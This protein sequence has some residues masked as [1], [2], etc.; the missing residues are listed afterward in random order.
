MTHK[1]N[2]TL[3]TVNHKK[4]EGIKF[5]K[6]GKLCYFCQTLSANCKNQSNIH[7]YCTCN[8]GR[9]H[10][11]FF[12]ETDLLAD[13]PNFS[14]TN[15][16]SFTLSYL[17]RQAAFLLETAVGFCSH[18]TVVVMPQVLFCGLIFNLCYVSL[19]VTTLTV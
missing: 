6:F 19:L 7:T 1:V 8:C 5:G 18:V 2:L 12:R 16:S 4:L 14:P 17:N 15:F 11:T 10:K 13:L 9:I 3:S